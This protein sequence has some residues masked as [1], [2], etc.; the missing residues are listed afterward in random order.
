MHELAA[1]P[2]TLTHGD[3]RLENMFF[4]GAGT[5]DFTVIDWQTSGLI[6]NGVYDVAY[7]MVS[8]VPTE[9]RRRIEREALQE[10]HGIL[11]SMGA[12]DLAFEDCW[13]RYRRNILGMLV[14]GVCAG[15]GA[16]YVPPTD[17]NSGRSNAQEDAGGH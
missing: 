7:F 8:S 2:Q 5:D 12:R 4:G 9:V 14:P 17:T 13:H 10:Y 6:G 3:F 15:G 16:G 1:G 11:C